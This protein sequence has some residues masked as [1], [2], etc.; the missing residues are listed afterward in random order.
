MSLEPRAKHDNSHSTISSRETAISN[1][2]VL[3]TTY[4]LQ[5]ITCI[6]RSA[7]SVQ[8]PAFHLQPIT[9][10]CIPLYLRSAFS[11]SRSAFLNFTYNLSLQ[12]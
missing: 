2:C 10:N 3:L 7:L 8:P 11:V 12:T 6:P 5:R 9:Y 4:N 1:L